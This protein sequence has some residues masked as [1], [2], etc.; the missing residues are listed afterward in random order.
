MAASPPADPPKKARVSSVAIRIRLRFFTAF[1]LSMPKAAKVTAFT[2]RRYA[3]NILWDA[4]MRDRLQ[5]LE[6]EEPTV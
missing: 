6:K 2:A 5:A 1:H 3:E 4:K